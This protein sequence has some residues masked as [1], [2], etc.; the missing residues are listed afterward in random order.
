MGRDMRNEAARFVQLIDALYNYGVKLLMAA[1]AEPGGLY[2]SGDGSF[3]FKRT[4]SRL[5]EMRSRDYLERGHGLN[6]ESEG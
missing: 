4:I 1:D 2:P 6:G 5:M 3:E